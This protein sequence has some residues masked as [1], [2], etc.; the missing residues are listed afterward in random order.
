MDV[1]MLADQQNLIYIILE[2]TQHVS[3]K[4]CGERWIIGMDGE[5][6]REKE[7]E[8]G[9]SVLSARLDDDEEEEEDIQ[10][11]YLCNI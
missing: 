4:I 6:E 2:R 10:S 5:R 3:W 7:R 11:V 8:S 9:K 1:P